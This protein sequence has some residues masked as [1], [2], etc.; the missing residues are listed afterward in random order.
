MEYIF[1]I[2]WKL[3][4]GLSAEFVDKVT[5]IGLDDLPADTTYEEAKEMALNDFKMQR[6]GKGCEREYRG[7]NERDYEIT[8][9]CDG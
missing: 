7:T 8:D 5:E 3:R 4:K 9:I 6:C 1:I 2:H